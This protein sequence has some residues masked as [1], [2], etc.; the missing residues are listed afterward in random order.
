MDAPQRKPSFKNAVRGGLN[1]FTAP[2]SGPRHALL[3]WYL[4]RYQTRYRRARIW[5]GIDLVLLAVAALLMVTAIAAGV[6]SPAPRR[7]AVSAVPVGEVRTGDLAELAITV[8]NHSPEVIGDA[9]LTMSSRENFIVRGDQTTPLGTLERQE[10]K[11]VLVKGLY[12]GEPGKPQALIATVAGTVKGLAIQ[13]PVLLSLEAKESVITVAIE[14][15]GIMPSDTPFDATIKIKS[16]SKSEL[17]EVLVRV[18]FYTGLMEAP[19]PPLPKITKIYSVE[20]LGSE[21]ESFTVLDLLITGTHDGDDG[22]ELFVTIGTKAYGRDIVLA[23]AHQSIKAVKVPL[24][25]SALNIEPIVPGFDA[26]VALNINNTGK[27]TLSIDAVSFYGSPKIFEPSEIIIRGNDPRLGKL[28]GGASAEPSFTLKTRTDIPTVILDEDATLRVA[29]Q[30]AVDGTPVALRLDP[31]ALAFH[32]S[33]H[34]KAE[35]QYYSPEGDQLGRGPDPPRVGKKT[36]YWVFITPTISYAPL[37]DVALEITV[38]KNVAWAEGV[39]LPQGWLPPTVS[40][41]GSLI[42]RGPDLVPGTDL[43]VIGLALAITPTQDQIGAPAP[44]VLSTVMTGAANGLKAG[45]GSLEPILT[46]P[47]RH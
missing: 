5:F 29:V 24:R 32:P 14:T 40:P 18:E 19:T 33:V 22:G 16:S 41:T 15:P 26:A 23:T 42:L 9:K 11:T 4:E 10:T 27:D 43:G 1:I 28:A 34:I 20:K 30:T 31:V 47:I 21:G 45:G 39:S 12:L 25:I 38:P 3:R 36:T 6:R 2:V 8:T 37:Q 17:D 7:L 13:E 46:A 35:A 44:L